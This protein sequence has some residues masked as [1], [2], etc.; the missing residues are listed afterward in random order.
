M[1]SP[2]DREMKHVEVKVSLLEP[3][4][5]FKG[6]ASVYEKPDLGNE[7]VKKGAFTKTI[8]ERGSVPILWQ[9]D[10]KQPIGSGV[11]TDSDDGLVIK[12]QLSLGVRRAKE[13]YELLKDKVISGLSIGFQTMKDE[14]KDGS[15][16]IK[17]A[18]LW[19]VSVVTFP[20]NTDAV[21]SSIKA[22]ETP[23]LPVGP[24]VTSTEAWD[25]AD[26]AI[27]IEDKAGRRHSA[28][29]L[30]AMDQIK[31]SLAKI[32]DD[33]NAL[34]TADLGSDDKAAA[35]PIEPEPAPEPVSVPDHSALQELAKIADTA[36]R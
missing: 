17:E 2:N 10:E 18:K 8:K 26:A 30:A 11:L 25:R 23:A 28:S 14:M 12:G 9:H 1:P 27:D 20:M 7:I 4:G 16:L 21:V 13:A 34:F 6:M 35:P 22:D 29:T 15:R 33:I 3:D 5:T 36:F 19:E 32:S 31:A 24:F